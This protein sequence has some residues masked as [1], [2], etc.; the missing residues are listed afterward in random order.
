MDGQTECAGRT[1]PPRR[2]HTPSRAVGVPSSDAATAVRGI[3]RAASSPVT[4]SPVRRADRRPLDAVVVPPTDRLTN[5]SWLMTEE[6]AVFETGRGNGSGC[7]RSGRLQ[8]VRSIRAMRPALAAPFIAS[9][10]TVVVV[11]VGRAP[12][13]TDRWA[14]APVLRVVFIRTAAAAA[15]CPAM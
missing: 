3:A 10:T 2:A 11:V 5:R 9:A 1:H 7:G 14:V 8:A 6:A 13:T 15:A 4:R 12:I